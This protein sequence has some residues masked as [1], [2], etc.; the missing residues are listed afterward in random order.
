MSILIAYAS[1]HGCTEGCAAKLAQRLGGKV[2]LY[3]L[4]S[5]KAIDIS[6]YD[7]V[8]IGSSVYVGKVNKEATEFCNKNLGE[9]I[10]KKL[11]LFICGS[12]EGDGLKQELDAAYPQEL[13]SKAIAIEC[14][15]GEFTF[16]KMNF[17]EK[18]IVKV[19]SKTN[20]DTSTIK[21]DKIDSFAQ[22]MKNA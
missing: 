16:G 10:N 21:D 9:L 12:Q 1:K 11:G 8:I 4:K 19:I 3:N 15:G 13:Q 18:T 20:K 22:I 7:K 17:M 14:F 6:Q 5:G 2:E